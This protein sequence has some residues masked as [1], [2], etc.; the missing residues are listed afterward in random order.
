[1][2]FPLNAYL[3][4]LL[5]GFSTAF[6]TLP[7]WRKWCLK[8]GLVDEPGQ[9]KIHADPVP[10]AGGL[11]VLTGL[12]LPLAGGAIAVKL[13]LLGINAAGF[14]SYGMSRRAMELIAIVLGALG[15][16]AL[17]CWDDKH[18]LRPAAKFGAQ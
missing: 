5:G 17:G 2:T 12:T 10:L 4:A 13:D 7:L 6:L 18:E 15:M 11:A 14:L 9:R 8:V 16:V 1:M 3:L